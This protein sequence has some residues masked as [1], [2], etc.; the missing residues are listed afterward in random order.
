MRALGG[1]R[2]HSAVR[3]QPKGSTHHCAK[4]SHARLRPQRRGG[5][6]VARAEEEQRAQSKL[7][8]LQRARFASDSAVAG[9]ANM[10]F[11]SPL[12]TLDIADNASV[13]AAPRCGACTPHK[14]TLTAT[15]A[16]AFRA[17]PARSKHATSAAWCSPPAHA[18]RASHP[19][20]PRPCALTPSSNFYSSFE[21]RAAPRAGTSTSACT[22]ASPR[23]ATA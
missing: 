2:S 11:R 3:S 13:A 10:T 21:R 12:S 6:G 5:A 22:R 7:A 19:W 23:R 4:P 17:R 20:R 9:D 8:A 18:R 1:G 15:R 16:L 14:R